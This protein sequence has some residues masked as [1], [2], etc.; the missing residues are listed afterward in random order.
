MPEGGP[1]LDFSQSNSSYQVTKLSLKSIGFKVNAVND[2]KNK[3]KADA[4]NLADGDAF[5]AEFRK[6]FTNSSRIKS[7]DDNGGP[8]N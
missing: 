2:I 8:N 5:V 4:D 6:N 3:N 7:D 1:I